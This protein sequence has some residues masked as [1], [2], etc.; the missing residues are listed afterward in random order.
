M[1]RAKEFYN[2]SA[3]EIGTE[4]VF[5]RTGATKPYAF[6]KEQLRDVREQIAREFAAMN[7]S[8]EFRGFTAR[9]FPRECMSCKFAKSVSGGC[10]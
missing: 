7:A 6:Y 1:F 4:L 5:I 2:R 8:Y 9:P 3:D 10:A